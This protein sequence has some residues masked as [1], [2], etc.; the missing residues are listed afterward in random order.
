MPGCT[1]KSSGKKVA[2]LELVDAGGQRVGI[3]SDVV[4]GGD[5]SSV[6]T[7]ID[8]GN[9][10]LNRR[11]SQNAGDDGEELELHFEGRW[12][13]ARLWLRGRGVLEGLEAVCFDEKRKLT[14]RGG[15]N[16]TLYY[17]LDGR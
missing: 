7:S 5:G 11:G 16:D 15:N 3:R 9:S 6:V 14:F 17:K 1:H 2:R 4:K 12:L 8:R 13:Q 10:G